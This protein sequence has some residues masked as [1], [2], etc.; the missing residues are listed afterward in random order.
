M[1]LDLLMANGVVRRGTT[2]E[3]PHPRFHERAFALVPAAE[4]VPEWVHPFLGRC[5]ADLAKEATAADPES[6][7]SKSPFSV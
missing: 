7:F 2:L 3:L 5:L 6:L 1:D 4:L